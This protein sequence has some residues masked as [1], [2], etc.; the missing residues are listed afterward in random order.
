MEAKT[1]KNTIAA[2]VGGLAVSLG[3]HALL[4]SVVNALNAPKTPNHMAVTE[5]AENHTQLADKNFEMIG[6]LMKA[7][8][9]AE[10]VG[11]D[12]QTRTYARWEIGTDGPGGSGATL[13]VFGYLHEGPIGPNS[14]MLLPQQINHT[15][16]VIRGTMFDGNVLM[17]SMRDV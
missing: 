8:V 3:G 12:G 11:R 6:R 13:P 7:P 2:A 5:V 10:L 14:G 1:T 16:V 4:N 17:F 9:L 15:P